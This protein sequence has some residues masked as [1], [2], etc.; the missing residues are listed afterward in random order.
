MNER[1]PEVFRARF[2]TTR[3]NFVVEARR[4]WAPLGVDRFYN[5]IR[6]GFFEDVRFFRVIEG[7]MAQFGIS[8]RPAVA[9]AWHSA[10]IPDDPVAASNTRGRVTFATAGPGTRTTQLFINY[11]DNSRLDGM[12]FSPIGEVIEGMEVVDALYA[13]YGEGAPRG[14]GPDQGRIHKEGNEYLG[15]EFPDLD[16]IRRAVIVE[17]PAD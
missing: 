2:E 9:A 8:G 10:R 14:R 6:E 17:E 11:S 12:G 5:L 1:A 15:R 7:F 4:E 13:G 3:G 16:S